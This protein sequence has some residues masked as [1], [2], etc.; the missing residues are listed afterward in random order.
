[1]KA[2]AEANADA[3]KKE[4]EVADKLNKADTL[5]FTQEKMIDEQKGNL[6]SD[7]KSKLEGLVNSLKECIKTKDVS[8]I[9][10]IEKEINDTWQ[11]VSQRV[12]GQQQPQTEQQQTTEQPQTEQTTSEQPDVQDAEFEE[13]N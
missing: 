13:V 9:D 12:Y 3:D 5:A 6:T 7:E 11:N 4:R 1:M 8:K 2:E 10:S